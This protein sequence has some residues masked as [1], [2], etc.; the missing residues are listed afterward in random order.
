[1]LLGPGAARDA[2]GSDGGAEIRIGSGVWSPWSGVAR[3]LTPSISIRLQTPDSRLQT[4]DT[5]MRTLS[6]DLRYGA[7]M[8]IKTPG[9]TLITILTLALGIGANSALFS[10]VNAVLLSPL[11]FRDS[12]RL[13]AVGQNSSKNR[14]GLSSVSHR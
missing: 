3:Q 14:A 7:R 5:C 4:P 1:G 6:Q 9:F 8:L 10:M 2:G 11:P 12:D 13:V